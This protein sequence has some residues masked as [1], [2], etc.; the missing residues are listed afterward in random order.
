M[1]EFKNGELRDFKTNKCLFCFV[2]IIIII[3]AYA[4]CICTAYCEPWFYVEMH[5]K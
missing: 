3:M 4:I 2:F 5:Y 1:Y